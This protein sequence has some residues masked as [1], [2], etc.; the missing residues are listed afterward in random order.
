MD[1]HEVSDL[2][3]TVRVRLYPTPEQAALVRPH[4]HPPSRRRSRALRLAALERL[5]FPRQPFQPAFE[6]TC[7][8]TG[9]LTSRLVPLAALLALLAVLVLAACGGST[10]S[11]GVPGSGARIPSQR[12][13][14][15]VSATAT[16]SAA[17]AAVSPAIVS[18]VAIGASDA[19]GVGASDPAHQ[20]YVP[21][22]IARLPS[23]AH[24]LNLGISGITIHPALT[25][26]LPDALTAHPTFI[27]VWM[28]G[29]DFR[30]C[31]PLPR[32]SADLDNMLGQLEQTGAK[33]FVA[34]TPDMSQLPY[35]KA[36]APGG[37]TCVLGATTAQVRALALQWNAIINPIVAKHHAVLVNLFVSD[38]ASHPEYVS[39]DGFHPSSLGYAR[40]ADLFWGQITADHAV[41]STP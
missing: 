24:A 19:I 18:Y 35:F 5:M 3:T 10:P 36:G 7:G 26:E 39:S 34:N 32:Y 27:T 8:P 41:P 22:I 11:T 4:C 13:T 29:N 16:A 33:V 15:A 17:R 30:Q 37:G 9:R 31:T 6:R 25:Q 21:R 12:A 20:G 38:L 2:K 23:S 40:L 1:D 28:V 14:A